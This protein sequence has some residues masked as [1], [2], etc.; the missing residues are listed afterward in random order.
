MQH[1]E[2][3]TT[4]GISAVLISVAKVL[5][6]TILFQHT[7]SAVYLSHQSL[8]VSMVVLVHEYNTLPADHY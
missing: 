2:F 8:V 3:T 1:I 7:C 4:C 5:K 6:S